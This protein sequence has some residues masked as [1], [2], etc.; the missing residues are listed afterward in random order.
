MA[1]IGRR[2]TLG[3]AALC[4]ALSRAARAETAAPP[5][6]ARPEDVG[7]SLE[8][9]QR[10]VAAT[11][12]NIDEGLIPGAVMLVGRRGKV[13]WASVQGRQGPD[14]PAP[15]AWDSIFR[16]YSMTKPLTSIVVMQLVEE[17]RL[18]IGDP[19]AK[20]LPEIGRMK[21]G[22]E[23]VVDGKRVLHLADPD[24]AM[25]VQD[26][27]RHTSGLTYGSRGT[28]LVQQAYVEAGIG[29]RTVA[30][31]EM[32]RRLSGL[33]LMFSP[34][35]RW[36]YSVSVDVLGRLIEVVTGKKFGV[37]LGER[38]LQPLGMID[39]GFQVPADK[40]GRVAQPGQKPGGPPMT[41]RFRVDDGARYE[42][43]GGGL[44]GT[45]DD[46]L[47]FVLALAQGGS[48]QGRRVIGRRTLEF[49]ASDHVGSRPGRPD[50]LGFGLGFEV[51]TKPGEAA[52][53]GS[54]GEYGWSGAAGTTFW[55]D[56]REQLFA[57]YM[58]QA[59]EGDTRFLNR[60]FG[61]MV[62]AAVVD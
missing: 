6:T 53:A 21:V 27:L 18:Q 17:G 31:D 46:Y 40:L 49:M 30:L 15:M 41:P 2:R 19:V 50:G 48:W 24:R 35:E 39:T 60:Q 37:A 51:R 62:Q 25:T 8:R 59:S 9:L 52:L 5:I 7:L 54:V 44:I 61:S 1:V 23:V 4:L 56:P 43:G 29:D 36:E 42:N 16:L 57:I 14:S 26:L 11:Q 20:Y 47:R 45:T 13:A 33:P 10:L 12:K 34:G 38:V 22:R 55:V 58:V 32:V 3:M 28:S